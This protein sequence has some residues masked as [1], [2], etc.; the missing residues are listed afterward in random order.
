MKEEH[1]SKVEVMALMVSL[2]QH[3]RE[4]CEAQLREHDAE[5]NRVLRE[6]NKVK[7]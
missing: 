1:K 6:D 2:E 7:K 5:L 4:E 3:Y